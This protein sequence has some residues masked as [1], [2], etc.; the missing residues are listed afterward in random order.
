M[1]DVGRPE[2]TMDD[3]PSGQVV[4][5]HIDFFPECVVLS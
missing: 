4:E 2:V 3:V 1:Y 5:N